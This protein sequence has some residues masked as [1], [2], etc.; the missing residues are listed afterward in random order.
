MHTH[1]C[2]HRHT[3]IFTNVCAIYYLLS[4][5]IYNINRHYKA[6]AVS[7]SHVL[8]YYTVVIEV[9]FTESLFSGNETS[10]VIDITIMATGVTQNPYQV[11]VVP[12]QTTPPFAIG[13]CL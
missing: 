11:V 8:L 1:T 9:A 5:Y 6:V 10:G 4:L 2:I 12:A 3:C 13:I 7:L